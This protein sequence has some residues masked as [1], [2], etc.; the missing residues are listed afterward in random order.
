MQDRAFRQRRRPTEVSLAISPGIGD[1]RT[2]MAGQGASA[3]SGRY[4]FLSYARLP[5]LPP[6][7][8]TDMTDPPDGWVC[9]FFQDLS[10]AVSHRAASGSGLRPGFLDME[11]SSG[12]RGRHGLA[13]ELGTAE[14]FVPLLSPHYYR[15]SWPRTEWASFEQRLREA[16]VAEPQWRFAPVLWEP[17]PTSEQPPGLADALSLADGGTVRPYAD[18]GLRALLR[19]PAYRSHYHQIVG[20]L[21]TRIV[22]IAEKGPLGPSP[23]SLYEVDGLPSQGTGDK[24]FAVVVTGGPGGRGG[25]QPAEY[26]RLAAERRSFAVRIADFAQ[27]AD[28]LGQMPGVLLVD[29][30]SVTGDEAWQDLDAKVAGLPSWVLPV[31]VASRATRDPVDDRWTL[32]ERSRRSYQRKPDVVRR[33]LQGVGSLREL[34]TLMP[35]LVTY[36][37]REYLRHGPTQR[38]ASRPAPRP[39]LAGSGQPI[40]S[41]AKENPYV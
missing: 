8:G 25:A 41:P 19:L 10:D 35:D 32:L 21:A 4:F 30:D 38:P 6:V 11:V 16:H 34:L 15:R 33:G 26:A 28:Q 18:F 24:V 27:S 14:V 17:L 1:V 39:R 20:E 7:P 13:D 3:I 23:M 29:P 5:P 31:I 12:P 9:E 40:D 2:A 37:E 22:S 36:A